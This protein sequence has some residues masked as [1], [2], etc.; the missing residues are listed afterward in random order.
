MILATDLERFI[1]WTTHYGSA[2]RVLNLECL[3]LCDRS[4]RCGD[5]LAKM[6]TSCNLVSRA[7][8]KGLLIGGL[9]LADES[10]DKSKEEPSL[11]D[12]L[13]STKCQQ[14]HTEATPRAAE[15]EYSCHQGR[16]I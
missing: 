4:S 6:L 1:S 15:G 12:G 16:Y 11:S 2:I 14:S 8:E 7:K 9:S 10:D 13:W 3:A 5:W